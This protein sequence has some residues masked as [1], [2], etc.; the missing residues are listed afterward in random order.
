MRESSGWAEV[1]RAEFRR[2][3]ERG[4]LEIAV[5]VPVAEEGELAM[6]P[7]SGLP[8]ECDAGVVSMG[9]CVVAGAVI[10]GGGCCCAVG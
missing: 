8:A 1:D 6:G 2:E 3:L 10:I 5:S 4:G 9:I 7:G